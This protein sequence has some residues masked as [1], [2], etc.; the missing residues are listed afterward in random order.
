MSIRC[1]SLTSSSPFVINAAVRLMTASPQ[2]TRALSSAVSPSTLNNAASITAAAAAAASIA[3]VAG[4]SALAVARGGSL[5]QTAAMARRPSSSALSALCPPRSASG[6]MPVTVRCYHD[7]PTGGVGGSVIAG[8]SSMAG[9]VAETAAPAS[10]E[11]LPF[12]PSRTSINSHATSPSNSMAF[13]ASS[14]GQ[15][16]DRASGL[17]AERFDER[18]DA[19]LMHEW[20]SL[21]KDASQH[22]S[23]GAPAFCASW[24][25]LCQ[26]TGTSTFP[27][28]RGA[29]LIARA[30]SPN[31][32]AVIAETEYRLAELVE[33]A[34]A[35]LPRNFSG[36]QRDVAIAA[37]A[38]LK[39]MAE[40]NYVKN[41]STEVFSDYNC[42]MIDVVLRTRRGAPVLL[43]TIFMAV[44][45]R[46]GFESYGFALRPDLMVAC[47]A[48]R[49]PDGGIT[50]P[51]DFHWIVDAFRGEIRSVAEMKDAIDLDVAASGDA[52]Q[53]RP[54]LAVYDRILLNI[55]RCIEQSRTRW[56]GR[57][58]DALLTIH[59]QYVQDAG[60]WSFLQRTNKSMLGGVVVHTVSSAN[61][62]SNGATVATAAAAVA[63]PVE[64]W[65]PSA[66]AMTATAGVDSLAGSDLSAE[67]LNLLPPYSSL[68]KILGVISIIRFLKHERALIHVQRIPLSTSEAEMRLKDV[69]EH[70]QMQ[71][72]SANGTAGA[73]AMESALASTAMNAAATAAAGGQPKKPASPLE[74]APFIATPQRHNLYH[75]RRAMALLEDI[76]DLIKDF[77]PDSI[78]PRRQQQLLP[79]YTKC[80]QIASEE[81]SR[82]WAAGMR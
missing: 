42:F 33:D 7:R 59:G 19:Q 29:V 50:P 22:A 5:P 2:P 39:A 53:L 35:H 21:V 34:R 38:V 18:E 46:L 72:V 54:L 75:A 48:N 70:R 8:P 11:R 10:G 37:Q 24:P 81:E 16:I 28:E 56:R 43:S 67:G 27:I 57:I 1:N 61:R 60:G 9:S 66:N 6:S 74:Q 20:R 4:C 30:R 36:Q 79:L 44:M 15:L 51:G 3:A 65:Q 14:P 40:Q 52:K 32:L 82:R 45:Q 80:S 55:Y 63:A 78:A 58:I 68:K 31:P 17:E 77:L 26:A 71:E 23:G 12:V 62:Q 69:L 47:S 49:S 13:V 73:D 64:P 41:G 76:S 25:R